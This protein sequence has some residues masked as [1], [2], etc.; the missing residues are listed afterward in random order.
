MNTLQL[1]GDEGL[2]SWGKISCSDGQG[3]AETAD[4]ALK[5]GKVAGDLVDLCLSQALDSTGEP[6]NS[7][8]GSTDDGGSCGLQSR[9]NTGKVGVDCGG[10][11]SSCTDIILCSCDG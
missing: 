5:S 3:S 8:G 2:S 9:C 11:L 7:V 1:T 4:D 10:N 6:S